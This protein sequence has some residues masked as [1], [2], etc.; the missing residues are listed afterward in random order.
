M[1]ARRRPDHAARLFGAAQ[2]AQAQLRGANLL[3]TP[4]WQEQQT[5]IR[6]ALGDRAFDDAYG[7][8]TALSLDE[9]VAVALSIDH[10]DLAAGSDRF[11]SLTG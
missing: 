6:A 2:T 5:R 7:Q 4:F 9:A 10:P 1:R 8:G 3:W 11:V